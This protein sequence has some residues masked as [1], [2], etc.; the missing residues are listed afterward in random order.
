MIAEATHDNESGPNI[1]D[2]KFMKN[3]AAAPEAESKTRRR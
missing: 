3:A 2:L 1:R